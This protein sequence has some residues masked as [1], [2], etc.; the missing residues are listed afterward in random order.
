MLTRLVSYY[1]YTHQTPRALQIAASAFVKKGRG[2]WNKSAWSRPDARSAWTHDFQC[3][4]VDEPPLWEIHKLETNQWWRSNIRSAHSWCVWNSPRPN[5]RFILFLYSND[6]IAHCRIHFQSRTLSLAYAR[7]HTARPVRP[8][9]SPAASSWWGYGI[10]SIV[11]SWKLFYWSNTNRTG[12]AQEMIGSTD[13][14]SHWVCAWRSAIS[15]LVSFGLR[16]ES[17]N[18]YFRA[19]KKLPDDGFPSP[20]RQWYRIVLAHR[21]AQAL[22]PSIPDQCI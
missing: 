4:S 18:R 22:S 7:G 15:S 14:A 12:S 11:R 13:D 6:T 9:G 20:T 8:C 10:P 16:R 3:A 21:W 19:M 2:S 5:E 17:G 1:R